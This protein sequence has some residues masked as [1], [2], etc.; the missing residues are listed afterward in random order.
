LAAALLAIGVAALASTGGC[1]G[2][3]CDKAESRTKECVGTTADGA[4]G[5]QGPAEDCS[6]AVECQGNCYNQFD[7][8]VIKAFIKGEGP[9]KP[10]ADCLTQC[11]SSS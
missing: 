11:G 8:T 1:A 4:G 6:G 2:T 10:L 5:D 3:T 9:G 7:C